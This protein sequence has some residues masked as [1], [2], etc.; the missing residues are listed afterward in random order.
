MLGSDPLRPGPQGIEGSV[1]E[2]RLLWKEILHFTK[3]R[4]PHHL[5]HAAPRDDGGENVKF[6]FLHLCIDLKIN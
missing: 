3:L 2:G 6:A 4:R 5:I 1:A